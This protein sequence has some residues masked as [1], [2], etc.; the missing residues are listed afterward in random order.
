[1]D[2]HNVIKSGEIIYI[3]FIHEGMTSLGILP[4]DIYPYHLFVRGLEGLKFNT[5]IRVFLQA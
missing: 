3:N 5:C 1:M 2:M 4:E